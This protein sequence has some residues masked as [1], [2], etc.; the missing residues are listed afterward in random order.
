MTVT[1]THE[2]RIAIVAE[3]LYLANLLILPGIGFLLLLALARFARIE[4]GALASSHLNQ[5][6]RASL[7][8]GLLI[9]GVSL[10]AFAVAGSNALVVW[11][12]LI[13]YVVTCHA[14][15]VLLG[16]LGLTKALSGHCWRYPLIGPALP[17]G[18]PGAR[19][20]V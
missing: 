5:T 19:R 7:W 6:V 14:T 3:S 18:C 16:V 2:Q 12:L 11:T 17:A 15:L 8:A 4:P 9:V 1:R 13:L 20:H 10:A